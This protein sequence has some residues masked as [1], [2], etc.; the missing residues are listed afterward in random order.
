MGGEGGDDLAEAAGQDD[1]PPCVLAEEAQIAAHRGRALVEDAGG[2][3]GDMVP[4]QGQQGQ[5]AAQGLAE[6]QIAGHGLIGQGGDLG[7]DRRGVGRAGQG[8]VGQCLQRL[9]AHERRVEVEDIGGRLSHGLTL[10]YLR[11]CS[12]K[13]VARL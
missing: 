7:P 12:N 2:Q 5:A 6:R 3:F 8:D 1:D 13:R 11:S 4:G 10:A 9:D